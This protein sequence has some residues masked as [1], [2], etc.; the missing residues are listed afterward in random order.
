[1]DASLNFEP[2]TKKRGKQAVPVRM[3]HCDERGKK[4]EIERPKVAGRILPKVQQ[5]YQGMRFESR[6]ALVEQLLQDGA[7]NPRVIRQYSVRKAMVEEVVDELLAVGRLESIT[8]VR[9]ITYLLSDKEV[10]V[11]VRAAKE[12]H[13]RHTERR[14]K[15][16]AHKIRQ[17]T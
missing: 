6:D 5:M 10:K 11:Q 16:N 4:W 12:R 2:V 3:A 9:Y 14:E 13:K 1:M 7:V 17:R 15:R 8:K